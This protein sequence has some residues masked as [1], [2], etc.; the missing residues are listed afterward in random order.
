MEKKDE[1]LIT[2]LV[3]S[4]PELKQLMD[5]HQGLGEKIDDLSKRPYLST[6]E[7]M[8]RKRLQKQKLAGRDK[9]ESIL[10]EHRKS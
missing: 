6:E 5:E 3:G 1:E 10:A 4:N 9:I 2:N 7:S 8:E